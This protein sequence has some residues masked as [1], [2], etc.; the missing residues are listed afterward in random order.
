M[1]T[2]VDVQFFSNLNGLTLG[3]NWG[4]LIRLLDK[5]LVTGIDFTQ[6]I[7]A[8]IDAQGDVHITLYSAHNA[9][10]LQ[11][12]ELTGFTPA[13][14]NQK[15]RIKGVPSTA[16]LILKPKNAISETSITTV[17]NGKLASLGYEIIFR[18]SQDVKRV[19][20][21]KNPK[22]NHPFIRIDE[23]LTSPD[24]VSGVYT[25]T[26]AK[27]AMVGL[28]SDMTHI[29][30]YERSEIKQLPAGTAAQKWGVSGVGTNC[31]RGM[32]RWYWAHA[33]ESFIGTQYYDSTAPANG[34]RLFLICG[35]KDAFYF[36]RTF[37]VFGETA[38]I[39]GMGLINSAYTDNGFDDWFIHC[40]TVAGSAGTSYNPYNLTGSNP[41]FH[42]EAQS[43]GYMFL[44]ANTSSSHTVAYPIVPDFFSGES[45][46]FSGS[47]F[48]A[49]EIPIVDHGKKLRGSFKHACY[50]GNNL[51]ASGLI[52][53]W[54][55]NSLLSENSMYVFLGRSKACVFYLGELE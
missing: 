52:R 27:Y 10:L 37:R 35:D 54:G 38:Q 36:H 48:S 13:S 31:V 8:S 3:N 47:V 5:T 20:R 14:L 16:Q 21:A 25:S 42:A 29:D 40:S 4:D 18:D 7:S 44:A 6:I 43:S 55:A 17:G 45:T 50:S 11:V 49:L 32:H 53:Q 30:D 12:V 2:D 33:Q 22:S 15:Y 24:G 51:L 28:L 41:F 39:T 1:S 9:T 23:S 46:R 26:Y 34:D 19:Y